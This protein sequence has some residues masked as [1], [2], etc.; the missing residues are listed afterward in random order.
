[1]DHELRKIIT[2]DGH[3]P[4]LEY[5]GK[6]GEL[7]Y[8]V[9]SRVL[10]I[11]DGETAGGQIIS[12][13]GGS[14]GD[15]IFANNNVSMPDVAHFA[16]GG[17]TNY[18]RAEFG[19]EVYYSNNS[20]V[21]S[22]YV[23]TS[24][25]MGASYGEFRSMYN[26]NLGTRSALT[27]A[28]VEDTQ[29]G[30]FSG[31]VSQTPDMD[32]MY[33]VGTNT[34]DNIILGAAQ[35]EGSLVASDW[36]TALGTFNERYNINGI[37]TDRSLTNISGGTVASSKLVLTDAG[38][39]VVTQIDNYTGPNPGPYWYNA[40]GNIQLVSNEYTAG[41]SL[42][43]ASDGSLLM[44]GEYFSGIS[45]GNDTLALKYDPVG[46]IV[47]RK[48]WTDAYGLPCGSWNNVFAIDHEDNDNIYWVGT[49]SAYN[50]QYL[51]INDRDGNN[52]RI[53]LQIDDFIIRDMQ[54][55]DNTGNVCV[56]G[57][58]YIDSYLQ[59]ALSIINFKDE[60][61]SFNANIFVTGSI[62][63]SQT[64]TWNS[65]SIDPAH[66]NIVTMG[67]YTNG[68]NHKRPMISIWNVNGTHYPTWDVANGLDSTHE[69][70]GVA[71]YYDNSHVYSTFIDYTDGCSYV[72]KYINGNMNN[73][74]WQVKIGDANDTFVYDLAFDATGN[75]YVGGSSMGYNPPTTDTDFFLWKLNHQS[76]AIIWNLSMGS[77]ANELVTTTGTPNTA[78]CRGLAVYEDRVAMTGY[79]QS[80][81]DNHAIATTFQLPTDGSID[82]LSSLGA[83]IHT[84]NLGYANGD[85]ANAVVIPDTIANPPLTVTNAALLATT[86]TYSATTQEYHYDILS[87]SVIYPPERR[88]EWQ[89][90]VNGVIHL[91]QAGDILDSNGRSVIRDSVFPYSA[92][93]Q[94]NPVILDISKDIHI[95]VDNSTYGYELPNGTVD[96]QTIKLIAGVGITDITQIQVNGWFASNASNAIICSQINWTPFNLADNVNTFNTA[97]WYNGTWYATF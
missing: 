14:T 22:D 62:I 4:V 78:S 8:D 45:Q 11:S 65:V 6:A 5:I 15:Y 9:D 10:R 61:N 64:N 66:G 43:Y 67:T 18:G 47:W 42:A 83:F 16:S 56:V 92:D 2:K 77:E 74:L 73:K 39:K 88:N 19:T 52:I 70:D 63:S 53:P 34:H 95:L 25:Y 89:F 24:V 69:Y 44:L 59:P 28:G 32:S 85:F 23:D 58:R 12:G 31:V 38:V 86:N 35:Y 87:D 57:A 7:F 81:V 17:L 40:Y 3:Q 72:T 37:Y 1:M 41:A 71:A 33:V 29:A 30:R 60:G 90:D 91:P 36:A 50:K 82:N 84:W 51:G 80:A 79:T 49:S 55:L 26:L 48:D 13:S 27:Y 97:V 93:L 46:N 76:G 21:D 75:V 94:G 96:G 20:I 68:S 54:L